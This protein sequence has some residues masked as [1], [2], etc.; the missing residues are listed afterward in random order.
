MADLNAIMHNG[1]NL[2]VI[3]RVA[4]ETGLCLMVDAGIANIEKA[5]TVLRHGASEV[6]VGTETLTDISFVKEAVH[7]LGADR[8]VVSLDLRN[9]KLLAKFNFDVFPDP[10]AVLRELQE[11]GVKRVI[12]LDLARVGS[13]EGVDLGFLRRVLES[14]YVDVFVGGGVRNIDDLLVLRDMGVTGVLLATALHSGKITV[15]QLVAAELTLE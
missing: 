13:E 11:M 3:E 8:V 9:G 14:V 5:K 6:I 4:E 10:A 15:D 1:D 2:G 7:L 12:V